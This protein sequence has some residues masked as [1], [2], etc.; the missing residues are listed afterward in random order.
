MYVIVLHA[1]WRL[2]RP[3]CRAG[4]WDAT[5]SVT[6]S[7]GMKNARLTLGQPGKLLWV[8]IA[9]RQWKW[10]QTQWHNSDDAAAKYLLMGHKRR[11]LLARVE[12]N[13][14]ARQ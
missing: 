4:K 6:I 5:P 13:W 2:F 1:L 14:L 12:F 10:G 9:P 3:K 8:E 11:C 7:A